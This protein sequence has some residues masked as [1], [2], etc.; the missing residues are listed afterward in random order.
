M[1][2]IEIIW[3][4]QVKNGPGPVLWGYMIVRHVQFLPINQ[5]VY[6]TLNHI[7]SKHY[8]EVI[9]WP[10]LLKYLLTN[11]KCVFEVFHYYHLKKFFIVFNF[12]QF[13]HSLEFL[14]FSNII[15]SPPTLVGRHVVFVLS[16]CPSVRLSVRPSVRHTVC[17]RNSSETTEQNF[18]KLGR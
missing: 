13:K 16:V 2:D 9:S 14:K 12:S 15:M 10:I 7:F 8:S 3:Q 11:T 6:F 17:Q 4:K 1:N 5:L 18:M